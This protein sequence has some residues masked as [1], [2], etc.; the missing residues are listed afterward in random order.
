MVWGR[1][2]ATLNTFSILT[3]EFSKKYRITKIRTSLDATVNYSHSSS[4]GSITIISDSLF[5]CSS[6]VNWDLSDADREVDFFR[7]LDSPELERGRSSCEPLGDLAML[8]LL[9]CGVDREVYSSR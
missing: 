1:E 5:T 6:G 3:S 7:F 2:R 4:G 9:E 8:S